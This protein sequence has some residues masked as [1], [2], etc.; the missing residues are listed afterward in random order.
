MEM[1]VLS[2][3][4]KPTDSNNRRDHVG[5]TPNLSGVLLNISAP[6][7][8]ILNEFYGFTQ[9]LQHIPTSMIDHDLKSPFVQLSPG[10]A[11]GLWVLNRSVPASRR[12]RLG[13]PNVPNVFH[14]P[15]QFRQP[16]TS[17]ASKFSFKPFVTIPLVHIT[18]N[19]CN[20]TLWAAIAQSV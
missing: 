18:N 8:A 16:S 2:L 14:C 1:Y 11:P 10:Q 13:I 19:H 3:K 6:T 9:F 7:L 12:V 20:R 17:M 4:S 5:R 15:Q